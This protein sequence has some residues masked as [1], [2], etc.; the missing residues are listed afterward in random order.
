MKNKPKKP[1]IPAGRQ[2]TVRQ[3][4]VSVLTG[5]VLSVKDIS[6]DV[7][8]SEKQIYEHLQHIHKTVSKGGKKL[9]IIPAECR[10]CGFSFNKRERYKKPGK[11]PVCRRE[12]ITEPFFT[13]E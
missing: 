9:I 6:K 5:Q 4:I 11:C 8:I 12:S 13:I 10:K 3:N 2:E 7:S 1:F